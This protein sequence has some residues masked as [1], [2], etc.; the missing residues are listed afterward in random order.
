MTRTWFTA[1]STGCS[2]LSPPSYVSETHVGLQVNIFVDDRL[3]A[4]IADFGLAVISE[5]TG[6]GTATTHTGLK[7]TVAWMSPE[8]INGASRLAP[9]MDVYSFGIVWLTV[10]PACTCFSVAYVWYRCGRGRGRSKILARS[11]LSCAFRREIDRSAL[12]LRTAEARRSRRTCGHSSPRAGRRTHWR[13]RAWANSS[14][15]SRSW[16]PSQHGWYSSVG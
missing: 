16:T 5:A 14:K 13:A 9:S 15:A 3:S 7:G 2:S 6:G 10:R 1:T 12:C 11:R 8:R 4:K